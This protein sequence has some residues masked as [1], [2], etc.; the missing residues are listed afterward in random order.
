MCYKGYIK[1]GTVTEERHK[2]RDR[3]GETEREREREKKE[4]TFNDKV[5]HY[6]V[7]KVYTLPLSSDVVLVRFCFKLL[8]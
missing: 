5:Q 6:T 1:N 2:K 7:F 8:Q 3:G 4:S